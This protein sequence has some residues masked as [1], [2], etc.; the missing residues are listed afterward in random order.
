MQINLNQRTTH[1]LWKRACNSL[2]G[3]SINCQ[4]SM[5]GLLNVYLQVWSLLLYSPLLNDAFP[6][7]G[8]CGTTQVILG[9]NPIYGVTAVYAIV[10]GIFSTWFS[11]ISPGIP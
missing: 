10:L 6:L 7:R 11:P 9:K 1:R 5:A 4:G 2:S 3:E 8:L